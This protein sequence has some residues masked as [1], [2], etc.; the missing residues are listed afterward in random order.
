GDFG[1]SSQILVV[2]STLVTTSSHAILFV[3]F[4]PGTISSLL[5]I[6]NTIEGNWY[7]VYFSS[8]VFVDGGGIIVKGNTLSTMVDDDGVESSVCINAVDVRNGG[9]FDIEDNTMSS[10][11]GVYLFGDTTVRSAGLL[12]VA[13]CTFA[14]STRVVNS[15]LLYLDGSVTLEGGAQWRV[16]GNNVTAASVL[17]MPLPQ[18]KICLSGSGTTVVLSHNRQV[19]G[20][21]V[22]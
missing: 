6:K 19:G 5:L 15:G 14:G 10:A 11:N 3:D 8:A 20:N 16:E 13:D 7:A 9:Y 17:S 4:Y 22:F 1:A 12:R 2:G 18:H 21:T